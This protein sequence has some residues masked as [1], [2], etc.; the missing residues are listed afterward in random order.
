MLLFWRIIF[1]NELNIHVYNRFLHPLTD[2]IQRNLLGRPPSGHK[3]CPPLFWRNQRE[4]F[5][6]AW[7]FDKLTCAL[8]LCCAVG[9]HPMGEGKGGVSIPSTHNNY[10]IS[11][12]LYFL[13]RVCLHYI[14][15]M[16]SQQNGL[17]KKIYNY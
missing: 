11:K 14:F 12:P 8:L 6:S 13:Y 15:L 16:N 7:W 17:R 1:N 5:L 2:G 9:G 4:S 10:C 3:N